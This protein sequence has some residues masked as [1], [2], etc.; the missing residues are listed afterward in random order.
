MFDLF[1]SH[2]YILHPVYTPTARH[3]QVLIVYNDMIAIK[4]LCG[5]SDCLNHH[6]KRKRRALAGVSGGRPFSRAGVLPGQSSVG[7]RLRRT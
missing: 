2:F 4:R 1:L 7:V 3:L 6:G 5:C